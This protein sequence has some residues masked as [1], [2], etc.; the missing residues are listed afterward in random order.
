MADRRG[1]GWI[2]QERNE[3]QREEHRT[4]EQ[5]RQRA[6]GLTSKPVVRNAIEH[7]EKSAHRYAE[8]NHSEADAHVALYRAGEQ[9]GVMMGK[10]LN[11][12]QICLAPD[13][14]LAP[15]ARELKR[16]IAKKQAKAS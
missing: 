14:V 1:I 9:L 12:G 4:G 3:I 8:D 10:T 7:S 15:K 11:A 16:Q 2:L 5:K 13:Y 6:R